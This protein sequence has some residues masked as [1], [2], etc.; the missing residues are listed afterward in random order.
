MRCTNCGWENPENAAR[1]E[2]CNSPLDGPV[3]YE[4]ENVENSSNMNSTIREDQVF[5]RQGNDDNTCP[6]CGFPI[7]KGTRRCP[8]C[9]FEFGQSPKIQQAAPFV[10]PTPIKEASSNFDATVNPW[11]NPTGGK[12]FN[13]QPIAWENESSGLPALSY[14][15]ERVVLRRD[16]TDPANNTI[17]SKTQAEIS[18]ENG[19]WFL[20]DKSDQQSTFIHAGRKIELADGD[21]IVLG[22]RKFVFKA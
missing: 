4:P 8:N 12:K 16:N 6:S 9:G 14:V 11:S 5:P 17:T 3:D 10:V 13:L 15:G 21:I 2:K 19:K 22:N 7:R 20:E 18:S 1:C